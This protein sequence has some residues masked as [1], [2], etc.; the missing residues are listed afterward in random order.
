MWLGHR[1]ESYTVYAYTERLELIM[2]N[3][4]KSLRDVI[5]WK[6]ERHKGGNRDEAA[7]TEISAS[8]Y[9]IIGG[10]TTPDYLASRWATCFSWAR[11]FLHFSHSF[12]MPAK[13]DE[14]TFMATNMLAGY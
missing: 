6:L 10:P 4:P 2:M 11:P 8:G 7:E 1:T 3:K 5:R 13:L 9:D 12:T 14:L